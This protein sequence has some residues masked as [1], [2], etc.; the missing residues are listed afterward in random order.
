MV[1]FEGDDTG[2]GISQ[3]GG[4]PMY[5]FNVDD[6]FTRV[7]F[8]IVSLA[9]GVGGCIIPTPTPAPQTGTE[10]SCI[11]HIEGSG[12]LIRARACGPD[13]VPACQRACGD[14]GGTVA[15]NIAGAVEA[16]GNQCGPNAT[17]RLMA[18]AT[19]DS[20][21]VPLSPAGSSGTVTAGPGTSGLVRA[22]GVANVRIG[23]CIPDPDIGCPSAPFEIGNLHVA[24]GDFTVG[25]VSVQNGIFTN[26]GILFGHIAADGS[27]TIP[28]QGVSATAGG[29]I[30]G[31]RTSGNFIPTSDLTGVFD[32]AEGTFTLSASGQ[33]AGI[34]V[35]VDLGG[36]PQP[37]GTDTDRDGIPDATDNC[38]LVANADQRRV[39][40][41][42]I[43]P[44]PD[45]QLTSC[46]DFARIGNAQARDICGAPPLAITNDAPPLFP[47]GRTV[48]TW[49][50][51]DEAG[52]TNTATQVVTVNVRDPASC[53]P[54]GTN[55]IRARP[56]TGAGQ[57]LIGTDRADCIIGSSGGDLIDGRGGDDF[58]FGLGGGDN[59]SGGSGNDFISGGDGGDN[60]SGQDGDDFL[61]GGSGEDFLDG[62][63]G[64][65][66]IRGEEG[67]DFLNGGPG[68]DLLSGGSGADHVVGGGGDDTL[69]GDSGQ[70]TL[71]GG[72]GNDVLDGG[73]SVSQ[74][75][76]VGGSGVN[77]FTLCQSQR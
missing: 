6:L 57:V 10:W 28:A 34:A 33:S 4:N 59:I 44:P 75:I 20:Q 65:N 51:R 43:T 3:Y 53:C 48:V 61:L 11:C 41:I 42:T 31:I 30:R 12:E 52:N 55:I 63:P 38:P 50:A 69:L 46:T 26:E 39:A 15:F 73:D 64:R 21:R 19:P 76:C 32:P 23:F 22:T 14:A 45:V 72:N 1:R 37:R 67:D 36:T 17:T 66:T 8:A 35:S 58:I 24:F 71:E 16:T 40:A 54:P 13:G 29:R 47:P 9:L 2:K 60:V 68:N 74:N 56:N 62:G 18:A 7:R 27:F 5:K 70:D 77:S 25:G 49:S